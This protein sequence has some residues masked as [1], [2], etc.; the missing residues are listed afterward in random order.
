MPDITP[1]TENAEEPEPMTTSVDEIEE[2]PATG[3]DEV[4]EVSGKREKWD[5]LN[6]YSV[7]FIQELPQGDSVPADG[8]MAEIPVAVMEEEPVEEQPQEE[9]PAEVEEIPVETMEQPTEEAEPA[10][11]QEVLP[12]LLL[13]PPISI[14]SC[15][16][17]KRS[18]PKQNSPS[19]S[20]QPRLMCPLKRRSHLNC[21]V[22]LLENGLALPTN[23]TSRWRKRSKQKPRV[24][25]RSRRHPKARRRLRWRMGWMLGRK[26]HAPRE[27][28]GCDEAVN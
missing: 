24:K 19:Q 5:I 25:L 23:W 18:S 27:V 14:I 3:E 16:R 13:L 15:S 17:S 9:A 26:L 8:G 1:G 2:L 10:Q 11:E 4:V 12:T 28:Q 21:R 7:A 6:G 22:L 20:N